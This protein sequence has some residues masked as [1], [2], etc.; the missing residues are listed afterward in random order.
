MSATEPLNET[1]EKEKLNFFFF[2][3]TVTQV[4]PDSD[5]GASASVLKT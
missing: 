4:G 3:A 5:P 2:V 1:V